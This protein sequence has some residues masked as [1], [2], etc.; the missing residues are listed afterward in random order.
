MK[1]VLLFISIFLF[2]SLSVLAYETVIIKFPEGQLWVKSYYKKFGNE[3]ILQYVPHGQ[4]RNNWSESVVIHSYNHSTYP[5]QV[6]VNN[7]SIKM[8]KINPTSPYKTLKSRTDDVIIGR[9]TDNYKN[10][11]A[12]CEF[13]R[14]SRAHN[15]IVTIH[16]MNKNKVIFMEN[17]SEWYNRIKR[18]KFYNSYY[19]NDRTMNKSEYFE[20]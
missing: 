8:L 3:A 13:F 9:C 17:Y 6:F 16:Y 12:Q 14:A 7:N 4:S 19:R 2:V 1:R 10:I 15:G 18:A 11:E 5:I 20:L